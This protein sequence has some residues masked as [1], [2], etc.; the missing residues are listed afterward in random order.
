LKNP[1]CGSSGKDSFTLAI[2]HIAYGNETV[3]IDAIREQRPAFSPEQTSK[4]FADLMRS[5]NISFCISDKF[6]GEWVVEQMGKFGVTVEQCAKAKSELY[7]DLL[8]TLM[9]GRVELLDHP[10]AVSQ[11]ASLE[12]RNRSGGRAS[13]D[14]PV[15][16]HEDIANAI[17][18]AVSISLFKYG[19]Y[20]LNSMSDG[21][22]ETDTILAARRLREARLSSHWPTAFDKDGNRMVNYARCSVFK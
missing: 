17:A 18:G 16:Q 21:D 13:I 12:R 8:A 22:D 15:G 5:Y 3:T 9:S 10:R 19:G 6:A 2:A 7:L 1:R 14:A 11:I 4:E 20:N